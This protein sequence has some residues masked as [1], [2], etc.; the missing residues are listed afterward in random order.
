MKYLVIVLSVL[1]LGCSADNEV[2]PKKMIQSL[3]GEWT[4]EGSTVSG[5]FVVEN[6]SDTLTITSGTFSI[7]GGYKYTVINPQPVTAS[8]FFLEG[9]S[10]YLVLLKYSVSEDYNTITAL[11]FE[12]D[13]D[14]TPTVVGNEG[15]VITRKTQ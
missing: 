4:F 5:E 2:S 6:V 9:S 13:S 15:I 8:K 1:L 3:V 10:A 11:Q 14:L 12:Y 7:N